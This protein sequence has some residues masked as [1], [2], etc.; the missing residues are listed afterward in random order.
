MPGTLISISRSRHIFR[1]GLKAMHALCGDVHFSV[2]V[3]RGLLV[4]CLKSSALEVWAVRDSSD[5]AS[6]SLEME[7]NKPARLIA[8]FVSVGFKNRH[9]II[10]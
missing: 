8:H 1:I 2:Y 9:K 3:S 10:Y 7:N 5:T 6:G 4:S